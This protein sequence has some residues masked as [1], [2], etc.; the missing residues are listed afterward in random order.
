MK[1][2]R[3]EF[4]AG[5]STLADFWAFVAERHA[6]WVRRVAKLKYIADQNRKKPGS[7]P[8]HDG[9]PWTDDEIIAGAK[10]T[11]IFRELDRGTI[12]LRRMEAEMARLDFT[13]EDRLFNVMWYRMLNRDD[14]ASALGPVS[15]IGRL[16]RYVMTAQPLFTSAHQTF[17]PKGAGPGAGVRKFY[18]ETFHE[19]WRMRREL[20]LRIVAGE[21]LKAAFDAV[22]GCVI[23]V[24]P[25]IAYEIVTDLRFSLLAEAPDTMKWCN[26]NRGGGSAR[27]LR[28]LGYDESPAGAW[29]V[30]N[31]GI[32]AK[33]LPPHLS[34]H[35]PRGMGY[36]VHSVLPLLE[37]REVEHAL[38]EFDKYE[39]VR[40]GLGTVRG[41]RYRVTQAFDDGGFGA[42][43][44]VTEVPR[45]A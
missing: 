15:D 2:N 44:R 35:L 38:C 40:T 29:K 20:C 9:R 1:T 33:M 12:A 16:K 31:D 23:G 28:R 24:G 8:A 11:N 4:E 14:H 36:K 19:L 13:K 7:A 30:L 17:L 32:N 39:R 10:F 6:V 18:G 5:Q 27:G 25:F 42:G 26:I 43:L 21:T 37:L 3:E 22:K 41:G 34:Q 45:G